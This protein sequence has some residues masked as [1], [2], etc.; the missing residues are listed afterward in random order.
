MMEMEEKRQ[1][2]IDAIESLGGK[3]TAAQIY[4]NSEFDASKKSTN[5]RLYRMFSEGILTREKDSDEW[6]YSVAP[7]AP[8]VPDVANEPDPILEAISNGARAR[9]PDAYLHATRLRALAVSGA[10]GKDVS[11]WL[12][13]LA[14]LL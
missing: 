8:P 4:E 7:P 12:M 6:V 5:T 2:M 3:A 11:D 13:E 14:E 9:I 1:A 10:L